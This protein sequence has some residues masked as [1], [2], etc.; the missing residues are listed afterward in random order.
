MEGSER[1]PLAVIEGTPL[2][3]GPG[4]KVNAVVLGQA[5]LVLNRM[6]GVSDFNAFWGRGCCAKVCRDARD[7]M[8]YLLERF[9]GLAKGSTLQSDRLY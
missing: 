6:G 7:K 8:G 5:Y 9:D 4:R 2:L 3:V 1:E